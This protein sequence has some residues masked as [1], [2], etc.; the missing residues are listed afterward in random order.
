MSG[1]AADLV[2]GYADCRKK[3]FTDC[4]VFLANDS[5]LCLTYQKTRRNNLQKLGN[6]WDKR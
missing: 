1:D 5:E 2:Y 4:A 6:V 3:T